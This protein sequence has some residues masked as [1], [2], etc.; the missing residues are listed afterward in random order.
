MKSKAVI[1]RD[2]ALNDAD[3]AIAHYLDEDAEQA[4]LGFIAALSTRMRTSAEI[5]Q[6][7]HLAMRT[8]SI[9]PVCVAG[10]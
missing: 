4:A 8:R 6:P 9:C 3:E 7:D 5:L 2:V 10:L 1:L